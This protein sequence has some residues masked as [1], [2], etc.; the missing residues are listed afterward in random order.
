MVAYEFVGR[1]NGQ[2]GPIRNEGSPYRA[3]PLSSGKNSIRPDLFAWS[4]EGNHAMHLA[5]FAD[6]IPDAVSEVGVILRWLRR[7]G[8]ISI[9]AKAIRT[10]REEL[11]SG[12]GWDVLVSR[13]SMLRSFL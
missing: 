7:E 8:D 1:I 2:I 12:A 13:V 5:E 10:Y 4:I 3:C 6:L 9:R 11:T